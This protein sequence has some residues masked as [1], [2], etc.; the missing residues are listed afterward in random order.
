MTLD[1]LFKQREISERDDRLIRKQMDNILEKL[2]SL[3]FKHGHP[4]QS[5]FMIEYINGNPKVTL[6]D[7]N[8]IGPL[9]Q[10]CLSSEFEEYNKNNAYLRTR[11]KFN[12][13]EV[14]RRFEFMFG[15][16]VKNWEQLAA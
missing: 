13:T 15:Q 7:F 9:T 8:L 2:W 16:N 10:D 5:N 11:S 4:H 3:G 6:I 14:K 12:S 1:Q